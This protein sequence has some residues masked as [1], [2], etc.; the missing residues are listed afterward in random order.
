VNALI[1]DELIIKFDRRKSRFDGT[2]VH[3]EVLQK[4]CPI[5]E[6]RG[7]IPTIKTRKFIL[8]NISASIHSFS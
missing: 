8:L 2:E 4:P 1:K 6:K 5:L 3:K 7:S